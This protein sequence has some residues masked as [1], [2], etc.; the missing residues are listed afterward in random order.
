MN[1]KSNNAK[2]GYNDLSVLFDENN[3]ENIKPEI[4]Y[5]GVS[6]DSREIENGNI[7][8]AIIGE[9]I[10]GHTKIDHAF[11]NGAS[12]AIADRDKYKNTSGKP[13]IYVKDTTKALGILANHHRRR[14][15]YPVVAIAG[16]N[17]KTTT[18]E[19]TAHLLSVKT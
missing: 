5:N 7:F 10:D 2:F 12:L 15:R 14:Y 16:S 1:M 3:F 8:V 19:L 11:E 4:F 6:I 13:V 17:G 18:K 9:S